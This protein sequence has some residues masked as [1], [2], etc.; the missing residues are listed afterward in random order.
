MRRISIFGLGYVGCVSS[1]CLAAAGHDVTGVDMNE[2]K[3]KMI[4]GAQLPIVEPGVQAVLQ[5]A[6][7]A[8]KLRATTSAQEALDLSEMA[9]LCVGTP[10]H[11]SGQLD[12]EALTRVCREIGN[13]LRARR[14]QF[15]V[16]VRS[17]VL[18][19]MTERVVIPAM[20]EG[21]GSR[22]R[23]R[24]RFVVNPEFLREGTALKDFTQPPFTL[25]GCS[26]AASAA[27]M[28]ELYE[29]VNAPFIHTQIRTAEMV[30]YACNAFHAVKVGFANEI[31]DA[32]D[33]LGAD[34]QE[35][36]RIFRMDTKLNVSASY[37]RPG[38]AFGGSC[39]GKDLR[40]LLHAAGR[41]DAAL[42]MLR[43]VLPSN[44]LQIARG[45]E[46]VL[47]H[48]KRRVGMVGLAFKPGTDDLRESPLVAVAEALIGKGCDV[49]VLDRNVAVTRLVG[50]NRRYIEEEIPHIGALM[51]EDVDELLRHSEV[52][53]I[54]GT[55]DDA[56]DVLAAIEP[57]HVVVDLTRG[58]AQPRQV[59]LVEPRLAAG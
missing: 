13:G 39:L 40:A 51:C 47:K 45:I 33:A 41:E 1:A 20:Y 59:T 57:H 11:S 52:V 58:M 55:S 31:G 3:V 24:V 28:A 18:P 42:P 43:S 16:I 35:V 48:R 29:R 22:F 38:F 53:V 15:T 23:D 14:G 19:G 2:E 56:S 4:N 26:E 46:A 36:M 6:V 5:E 21:A 50:A 8:G 17:T 44:Q 32:C 25:V 27:L 10:G 37:L 12:A 49:R 54:G 34:A 30:K 7:A 9:M